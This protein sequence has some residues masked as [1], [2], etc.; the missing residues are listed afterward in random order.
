[1]TKIICLENHEIYKYEN[2][3]NKYCEYI[4]SAKVSLHNFK[5]GYDTIKIK[6]Y[7]DL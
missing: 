6:I 2:E 4:L 5:M 1:M 7:F 3:D